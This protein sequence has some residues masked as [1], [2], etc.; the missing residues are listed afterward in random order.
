MERVGGGGGMRTQR[1]DGLRWSTCQSEPAHQV[2]GISKEK[3]S[4]LG[5]DVWSRKDSFARTLVTVHMIL[6]DFLTFPHYWMPFTFL[7]S[8]IT[9]RIDAMSVVFNQAMNTARHMEAAG[10]PGGCWARLTWALLLRSSLILLMVSSEEMG[11]SCSFSWH[12]P[13]L[14]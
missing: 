10:L 6:K 8:G 5:M 11:H 4:K 13:F 1:L 7:P 2:L 12:H 14:S 9:A 3:W